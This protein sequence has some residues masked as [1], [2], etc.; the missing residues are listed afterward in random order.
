MQLNGNSVTVKDLELG[1]GSYTFSTWVYISG[2]NGG[3]P[4][5]FANKDWS[6]G[7]NA[8]ILVCPHTNGTLIV[9]F[10]GGTTAGR[11]D[12]KPSYPTDMLNR[13]MHLLVVIDKDAGEMRV[14]FDFGDFIS[15]SLGDNKG[16]SLDGDYDLVIGQDGTTSYMNGGN[17]YLKG[18][19]DDFIIFRGAFDMDDVRALKEYYSHN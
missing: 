5:L 4:V 8:G 3:D 1:T 13:W 10:S 19:V 9:N 11:V 2:T 14:S 18:Y 16:N 17:V 6:S 15:T 12:L 7:K